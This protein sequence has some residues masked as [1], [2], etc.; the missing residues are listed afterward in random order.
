VLIGWPSR[1]HI[2]RE[3]QIKLASSEHGAMGTARLV[4]NEEEMR[5]KV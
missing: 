3:H 1:G 2:G 4:E 5:N